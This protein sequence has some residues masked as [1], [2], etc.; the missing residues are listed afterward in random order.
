MLTVNQ[1]LPEGYNTVNF[2]IL[3]KGR[4]SPFIEF[5]EKVFGGVE[6][7]QVRTPDKDGLLIHAEVWL[8]NA[9]LL[10]ANAKPDWPFTPAFLQ[11]YV[12]DAQAVLDR[13]L[14]AGARVVTEVSGFYNNLKLA[15]FQDT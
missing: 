12:R 8:G 13:A 9:M 2:F 3:V 11:V 4:A 1:G 14:E 15:R 7:S 6:N 5:V 10:V